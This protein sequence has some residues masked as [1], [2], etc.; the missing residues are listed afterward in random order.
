MTNSSEDRRLFVPLNAGPF[1]WFQS[2]KKQWEVRLNRGA[3]RADRLTRDRRVELRHG[4]KGASLWGTLIESVR[5]SNAD[6][7]FERIPYETTV[8]TAT[9]KSEAA[10]FVNRLFRQRDELVGFRVELDAETPREFIP[11]DPAF[12]G[13]VLSGK[14]TTTVRAGH[15]SYLPGPAALEFGPSKRLDGAV[16]RA[17]RTSVD[18]LT[19]QDARRDGFTSR[20]ALLSALRRYYPDLAEGDPV[21]VVEFR[22]RPE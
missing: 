22:C 17:H 12:F 3:F 15:R 21:T 7:L 2:G 6:H 20:E 9:S 13:L 10:D 18:K 11:F 19:V 14:K 16:V 4:Y 1:E 8:P 5:S